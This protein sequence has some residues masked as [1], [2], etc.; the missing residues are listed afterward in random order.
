MNDFKNFLL[1][2]RGA[3]IGLLIAILLLALQIYKVIVAIIIIVACMMAGNFIQQNKE[4][5]KDRIKD[6]IDRF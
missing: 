1:K 2:Y 3:L 6:F 4:L 5:V